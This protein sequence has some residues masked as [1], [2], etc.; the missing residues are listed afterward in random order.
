M[1]TSTQHVSLRG[2]LG[3]RDV[4]RLAEDLGR[5]FDAPGP[6]TID[7]A[8]LT[9]IDL[10]VV[11]LLIA[12]RRTAGLTGCALTLRHAPDGP[13]ARLLKASGFLAS[14]GTALTPDARFWIDGEARAA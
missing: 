1:S 5:A 4:G 13:L 10:S 3:L 12:A 9:E 8:G 14:D 11:Q 6:V 7:C 2:N